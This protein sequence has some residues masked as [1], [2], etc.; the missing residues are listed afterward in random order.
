MQIYSFIWLL[1]ERNICI[2]QIEISNLS[3]ALLIGSF[4]LTTYSFATSAFCLA[5]LNTVNEGWP[6]RVKEAQ[7]TVHFYTA[8]A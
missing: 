4:L 5:A 8:D 3:E 2:R 7:A 1:L 6:V